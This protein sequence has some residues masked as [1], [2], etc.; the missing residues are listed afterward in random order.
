LQ[1]FPP[2]AR[3]L[4]AGAAR[5]RPDLGSWQPLLPVHVR[6]AQPGE[7]N[8]V[9]GLSARVRQVAW[10]LL[11]E[12]AGAPRV[13]Y[14]RISMRMI[15]ATLRDRDHTR[16]ALR[17][18]VMRAARRALVLTA[19]GGESAPDKRNTHSVKGIRN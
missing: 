8:Q 2:A 17:L 9:R 12:T 14:I 5:P 3:F 7:A 1:N 13:T 6:P 16:Y 15:T 4:A 18:A 19:G 11:S 10:R